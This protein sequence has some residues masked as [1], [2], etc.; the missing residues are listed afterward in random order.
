MSVDFPAPL[1][2]T[3]PVIPAATDTVSSSSAMTWAEYRFVRAAVSMTV[4]ASGS[5][6]G[7]APST[8][9]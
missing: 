5:P 7:S 4:P 2:P 6:A 8:G 9:A 1:A 3:R